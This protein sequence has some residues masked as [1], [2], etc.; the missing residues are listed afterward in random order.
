MSLP[1]RGDQDSK[2]TRHQNPGA[3]HTIAGKCLRLQSAKFIDSLENGRETRP[4]RQLLGRWFM[5]GV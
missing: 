3:F 1:H 2:P 4:R 5:R